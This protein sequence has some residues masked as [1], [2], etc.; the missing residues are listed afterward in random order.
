MSC[1]TQFAVERPCPAVPPE[2]QRR[3]AAEAQPDLFPFPVWVTWPA[4]LTCK[5][6]ESKYRVTD[7]STQAVEARFGIPH[8]GP[9]WVCESMGQVIE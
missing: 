6:G 1:L 2:A 3:Q 5:C 9:R 8:D 4:A 7:E